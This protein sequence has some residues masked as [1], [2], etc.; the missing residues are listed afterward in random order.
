MIVVLVRHAD[1]A[2]GGDNPG[3]ST[4]GRARA[5]TLARMLR[6][7]GITAIF[8]SELRRTKETGAPLAAELS[9]TPVETANDPVAAASQVRAAGKR[10]LVIGHS[11]TVP[12]IIKA[13]GGPAGVVINP[14]EFNRLFVLK[15]PADGA[16]SLLS[17][18]YGD[19]A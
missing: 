2:A 18:R 11:N 9:I 14:T 17:M 8:T 13:L 10:V 19:V 1:P 3:L 15:M 5:A 12:P 16:D 4:A 7:T 6:D